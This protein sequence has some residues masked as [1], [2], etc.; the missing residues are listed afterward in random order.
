MMPKEGGQGLVY[1]GWSVNLESS[2][3]TDFNKRHGCNLEGGGGT[4]VEAKADMWDQGTGWPIAETGRSYLEA[5]RSSL[6][7]SVF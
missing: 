7:W 4:N 6:W 3:Q 1:I 5:S 2:D